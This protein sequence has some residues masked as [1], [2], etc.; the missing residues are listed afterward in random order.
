MPAIGSSIFGGGAFGGTL[1]QGMAL[2]DMVLWENWVTKTG[3]LAYKEQGQKDTNYGLFYDSGTVALGRTM[4]LRNFRLLGEALRV[5]ITGRI[6]VRFEIYA[7][8]TGTSTWDKLVDKTTNTSSEWNT[9]FSIAVTSNTEYDA[10]QYKMYVN[11]TISR[12]YK[13]KGYGYLQQW[14]Q[15]GE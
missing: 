11:D 7:R 2:G 14:I 1:L 10:V 5:D 12:S 6:S 8:R 3:R 15:K 9:E 4:K 13:A